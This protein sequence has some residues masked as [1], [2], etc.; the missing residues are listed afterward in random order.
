MFMLPKTNRLILV[1]TLAIGGLLSGCSGG[2]ERAES[3]KQEQCETLLGAENVEAAVKA[4]GG[5]DVE[6]SGTPQADVLADRLAREAKRWQKSDLLHTPYTA[7]RM[8]AFEGD[9]IVGTVD[10]SVKWSV[11][12]VRMMD[13][14]QIGR[15]WRQV[16]ESLFVAPEP[17][18]A[19]M[20]LLA[21][22]AVPG[23]IASQPSDL[24]LQFEVA[25]KDLGT[26]LRW[27]LLSTFA[28]SVAGEMDC[29]KRPVVPS[30]LPTSG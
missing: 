16:N 29:E 19:R 13:N 11:L 14:P 23:A 5:S 15:T 25:A 17:G 1:A 22:C 26:E 30:A 20:Q 18:P 27:E 6:V 12:S 9:R 3:P 7:C 10:V 8:S 24:P 2:E 21:V 28:R 4:T